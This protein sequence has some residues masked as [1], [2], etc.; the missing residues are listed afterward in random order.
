MSLTSS[1]SNFSDMAVYPVRSEKRTV[2]C[3]RSPVMGDIS[4]AMVGLEGEAGGL[5]GPVI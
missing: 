2:T 1:G 4:A 3:L 5:F